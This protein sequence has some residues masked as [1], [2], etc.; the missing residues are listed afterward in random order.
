[1]SS[2][3]R[4]AG[5]TPNGQRASPSKH[6]RWLLIHGQRLRLSEQKKLGSAP[7][8]SRFSA[9]YFSCGGRATLRVRTRRTWAEFG[10]V[11]FFTGL[12]AGFDRSSAAA[13][14]GGGLLGSSSLGRAGEGVFLNAAT[15]NLLIQRQ[16]EFLVGSGC[17]A[18][19]Q[20]AR[21]ACPATEADSQTCRRLDGLSPS[22]FGR[23]S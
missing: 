13:L 9:D 16:D 5:G 17:C 21:R 4:R 6:H 3:R 7:K 10:M 18:D 22:L 8:L 2:T 20:Q 23:P 14:G 11:A 1:M 15:G 19:L 12:G